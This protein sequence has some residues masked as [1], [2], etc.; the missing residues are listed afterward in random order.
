M[1]HLLLV[2]PTG[3]PRSLRHGVEGSRHN[4]I[5]LSLLSFFRFPF[6]NFAFFLTLLCALC[7]PLSVNSVLPSLFLPSSLPLRSLRLRVKLSWVLLGFSS[8]KLTTEN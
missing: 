6:S 4:R 1:R 5:P 3:V 8:P 7:V 2:I